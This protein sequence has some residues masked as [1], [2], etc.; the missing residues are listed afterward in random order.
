MH[1]A[2]FYT[3]LPLSLSVA[4]TITSALSPHSSRSCFRGSLFLDLIHTSTSPGQLSRHR[5]HPG[6][7]EEEACLSPDCE[8][9]VGGGMVADPQRAAP[10]LGQY[11]RQPGVEL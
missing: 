1:M 3:L 8:V 9:G 7:C 2:E 4:C 11:K 10:D 5:L 6:L